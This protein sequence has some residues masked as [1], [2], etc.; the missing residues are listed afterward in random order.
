MILR[1]YSE[2]S[3]WA[4]SSNFVCRPEFVVRRPASVFQLFKHDLH[5]N[6]WASCYQISLRR[7]KE[8]VLKYHTLSTNIA[9]MPIYDKTFENFSIRRKLW[10]L[11][12]YMASG[13]QDLPNSSK[14]WLLTI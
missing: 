1:Q 5:W 8:N 2:I 14:R 13:A 6:S 9:D 4:I 7:G 11:M 10:S 12:W 3:E